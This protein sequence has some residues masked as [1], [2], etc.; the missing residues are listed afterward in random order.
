MKKLFIIACALL[1]CFSAGAQ[2]NT[3]LATFKSKLAWNPS[4]ETN[5]YTILG[6]DIGIS[7]TNVVA[8]SGTTNLLP[9]QILDGEL[10]LPVETNGVLNFIRVNGLT[11]TVIQF[12]DFVPAN[13]ASGTYK[14]WCRVVGS[15]VYTAPTWEV[16]VWTNVISDYNKNLNAVDGLK[17]IKK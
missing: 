3:N 15:N 13:Q 4:Q 11:N 8:V 16:S 14:F 17:V 10:T 2:A 7:T 9:N 6:Y 1:L 5:S 12:T